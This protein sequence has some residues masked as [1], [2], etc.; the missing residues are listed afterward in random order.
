MKNLT[1]LAILIA[2]STIGFVSAKP[3]Q[4]NPYYQ[5]HR[6]E[7]VRSYQP[8]YYYPKKSYSTYYY[9]PKKRYST[10]YYYPKKHP[11]IYRVRYY[12]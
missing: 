12:R 10:F 9:Y 8:Y 3:V 5:S 6:N 1:R 7:V 2:A 4:A 11:S